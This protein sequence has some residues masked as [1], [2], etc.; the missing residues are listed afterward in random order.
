MSNMFQCLSVI[1]VMSAAAMGASQ[2]AE[3][4]SLPARGGK[5]DWPSSEPH[6]WGLNSGTIQNICP[7]TKYW[8]MPLASPYDGWFWTTV[9][10]Q[11]AGSGNNVEC[12]MTGVDRSG[13]VFWASGWFPLPQ[14]GPARDINLQSYV[15]P[16]GAGMVDCRAAPGGQIHTLKWWL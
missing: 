12:H 15:P 11:A 5:S 16:G 4:G 8:Y 1:A 13:A 9:T 10:A 6:C 3:A 2:T 14:F 7:S